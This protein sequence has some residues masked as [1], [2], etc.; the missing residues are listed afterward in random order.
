[1]IVD[2]GYSEAVG[3]VR[4]QTVRWR[5]RSSWGCAARTRGWTDPSTDD[6]GGEPRWDWVLGYY[7]RIML[8]K[9]IYTYVNIYI[10][11]NYI[12]INIWRVLFQN[13]SNTILNIGLAMPMPGS[14][15]LVW[16]RTSV[17]TSIDQHIYEELNSKT[18]SPKLALTLHTHFLLDWRLS[19]FGKEFF[20]YIC[21]YE[22]RF[23][24]AQFVKLALTL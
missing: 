9:H 6:L 22:E 7:T 8:I 21:L 23:A 1:M 12:Y 24:K 3:G 19:R 17:Y 13:A 18:W 4:E 5:H 20:I 14:S 2:S 10:Y 11:T 16:K 15:L